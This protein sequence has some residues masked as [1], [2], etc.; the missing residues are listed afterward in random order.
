MFFYIFIFITLALLSYFVKRNIAVLSASIIAL[1]TIAGLRGINIGAD[2][3]AYYEY[4]EFIKKTHSGYMEPIWNWLNIVL[5]SIG[6][7]FNVFLFITSVLTLGVAGY[8]LW[9]E[10]KNPQFGLFL[11]YALYAYCNSFNGMRQYLAISVVLLGYYVLKNTRNI[12]AFIAVILIAMNIHHSAMLGF[13]TLPL[14][15]FNFNR[16]LALG[17]L[18]MSFVIGGTVFPDIDLSFLYGS[19]AKYTETG[20]WVRESALQSM[21]LALLMNIYVICML[22]TSSRNMRE[23]LY[24][25]IFIFGILI[26]N[27]TFRIEIMSRVILYFTIIQIVLIP[28]YLSNIEAK[29]LSKLV[30]KLFLL[31]YFSSIF[32]KMLILGNSGIYSI[33]PYVIQ[34]Y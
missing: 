13:L 28:I 2:T 8:V 30:I 4:F 19:Y 24:F 26:M 18:I 14:I 25:K 7:N 31:A 12:F 16:W 1:S 3:H 33:Y 5:S 32:F 21:L 15:Y 6:G 29:S 20:Y 22:F 17:V 23:N 27:L 11:Y 10:V 34:I 9:K